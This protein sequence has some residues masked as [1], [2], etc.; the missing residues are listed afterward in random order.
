MAV[1]TLAMRIALA[2]R[3]GHWYGRPDL[4]RATGAGR[5]NI[6]GR[7]ASMLRGGLVETARDPDAPGRHY[8]KGEQ[9]H[10]AASI[11]R[12]QP[13]WLFRLTDVGEALRRRA[14]LL[15]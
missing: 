7:I 11:A 14:A 8:P 5:N 15:A 9:I 13:E 2:M 12:R 3:P 4:E 1:F 10:S 6:R